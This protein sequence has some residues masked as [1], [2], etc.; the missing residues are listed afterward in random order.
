MS[1]LLEVSIK[2]VA[3]KELVVRVRDIHP[4]A[5]NVK[6]IENN[7]ERYAAP[8]GLSPFMLG[9]LL[10]GADGY[11]G[12]IPDFIKTFEKAEYLIYEGSLDNFDESRSYEHIDAYCVDDER[13]FMQFIE[14]SEIIEVGNADF[15][16][17]D[18]EDDLEYRYEDCP[19]VKVRVTLKEERWADAFDGLEFTTAFDITQ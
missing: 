19:Y 5:N 18:E 11:K 17:P 1:E 15:W 6:K 14:G 2:K 3:E 7:R 9:L 8:H 10:N 12:K 4:N 16:N 13:V